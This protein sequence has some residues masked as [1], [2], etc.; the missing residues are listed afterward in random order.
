MGSGTRPKKGATAPP[1]TPGPSSSSRPNPMV[2][3]QQV[4]SLLNRLDRLERRGVRW[5]AE[6]VAACYTMEQFLDYLEARQDDGTEAAPATASKS[7]GA[8]L[9]TTGAPPPTTGTATA[10]ASSTTADGRPE[11]RGKI[12]VTGGQSPQM[13]VPISRKIN[14]RALLRHLKLRRRTIPPRRE[15]ICQPRM[16][17][18]SQRWIAISFRV[19]C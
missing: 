4:P 7:A 14:P 10:P 12:A 9:P 19:L 18:G 15:L 11:P 8:P 3:M 13:K 17:Q 5:T 2:G 6:E 16:R 1:S